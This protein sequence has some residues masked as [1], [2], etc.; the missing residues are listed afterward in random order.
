[1]MM[2]IRTGTF[3]TLRDARTEWAVLEL[4]AAG[5]FISKNGELRRAF[6]I[7]GWYV[8]VVILFMILYA[9]KSSEDGVKGRPR[10]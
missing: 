5:F 4:I 9:Y 2:M 6:T 7:R 8:D 10:R 3:T 1:M